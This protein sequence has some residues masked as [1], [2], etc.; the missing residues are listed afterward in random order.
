MFSQ[1]VLLEL[2]INSSTICVLSPSNTKYLG[3][4]ALV[5][6][7]VTDKSDEFGSLK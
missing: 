6:F 1:N 5:L 2:F 7:H 3:S 4:S